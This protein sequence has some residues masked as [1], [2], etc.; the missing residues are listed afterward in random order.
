MFDALIGQQHIQQRLEHLVAQGTLP[1]SILMY[2]EKGLGTMV[3]AMGLASLL[4]GR[5]VFSPDGGQTFLSQ[6]DE[7]QQSLPI[8]MDD[9]QQVFWLRPMKSTLKVEQWYTLLQEH[10]HVG[11]EQTRVVIVEDF[12]KAN[13]VMANAMLK[14]IEEPPSHVYFILVSETIHTILPTIRSRCMILPFHSVDDETIRKALA[15]EGITDHVD[16]ALLTGRGNPALVKAMVQQDNHRLIQLAADMLQ[17]ITDD[18]AWFT[19][20]ALG[21]DGLEREEALQVMAWLR[22]ISRDMMTLLLGASTL[23]LPYLRSLYNR[24]LPKWTVSALEQVVPITID[25][26]RS[27]RL[28]MK[29]ALVM[30]GVAIGLHRAFKEA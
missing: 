12:H 27:L 29:V 7:K 9:Y 28:Y 15:K 18:A 30:D 1:H 14:T 5:S 23:Q 16:E 24:L 19:G 26:E 4:V 17:W 2:G 13:A 10:L 22:V 6:L 21:T 11:S 8:Y 20:I 3:M 25:G